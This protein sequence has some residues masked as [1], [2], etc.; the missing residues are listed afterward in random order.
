MERTRASMGGA[1]ASVERAYAS[2]GRACA[3]MHP[4]PTAPASGGCKGDCDARSAG[5]LHGTQH[6]RDWIPSR[7]SHLNLTIRGRYVGRG[8]TH[9]GRH[10]RATPA[11]RD[12][13]RRH[14]DESYH[15]HVRSHM[16]SPLS[17]NFNATNI[18]FFIITQDPDSHGLARHHFPRRTGSLS[19]SST[20][21]GRTAATQSRR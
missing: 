12:G 15:C 8:L 20:T 4:A 11:N 19:A 5:H 13:Y 3:P 18:T 9:L 10:R 14:C 6:L 16:S 2:M 17:L 21:R 7:S 1:R